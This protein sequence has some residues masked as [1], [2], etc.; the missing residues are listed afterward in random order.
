MRYLIV[1]LFFLV[2]VPPGTSGVA[3]AQDR[4][5]V[6]L[7]MTDDQGY[8]D[9]ASQGNPFIQTPHLDQLYSESVRLL[10]F[11]VDLVCT[12]TR[13]ALLTG[14]YSIRTGAWR[15]GAG[16]SL[17]RHDEVTVADVFAA[18]GYRTGMFGKWHL[19]DNYPYRP[20]DR[21]FQEAVWHRHGAIG[22]SG[23]AW[24]ND[25]NDDIYQRNGEREQFTG[26]C[27]DVFFDEALEFM[28]VERDR[29]FFVYLSTNAPHNPYTV[30]DRYSAPYR[31]K[32]LSAPLANFMGMVTN[33]DENIGRLMR[34]LKDWDLEDN[35]ILI[36]MTDNGALGGIRMEEGDSNGLPLEPWSRFGANMRGRKG[37]PYEG[38][39]RVPFFIRWPHGGLAGGKDVEGLTAHIDVMP[40]LMEFCGLESPSAVELDG[41]SLVPLLRGQALASERTLFVEHLGGS[42]ANPT[43][44]LQPYEISAVLTTRWRLVYGKELYDI[45]RDPMQKTNVAARYPRMVRKLRKK[46]ARWFSDVTRR[47]SEPCR[48]VLGDEAENPVRL[49]LQDWYMAKG[50]PPWYQRPFGP[51][52]DYGPYPYVGST[53]APYVNGEWMVEVAHSGHYEIMLRQLPSE[54]DFVIQAVQARIKIGHLDKTRAVPDGA[55]AVEF[56]VELNSGRQSLQTWFTEAGG[57]SRGA[58]YVEVRRMD[59]LG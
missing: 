34:K 22:M 10:D 18:A 13:A 53:P 24:G 57:K 27:T 1:G 2:P 19:G 51:G 52:P 4:P 7:I 39:H 44:E 58:F 20:H 36:F 26:Y 31:S 8:G 3:S 17:L 15:T 37:S 30:P 55:T 16:R 47:I 32:G 54:A 14:R 49:N 9:L 45:T 28:E 56:T 46:H 38:G 6:I 5:N 29:P 59:N 41:I 48:I 33:I 12:P 35:T 11:H 50:N 23:D 21:G 40:T 42:Y 25:Y 43:F